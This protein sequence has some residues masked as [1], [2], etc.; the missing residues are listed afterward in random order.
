[1]HSPFLNNNEVI[2]I[3]KNLCNNYLYN[4]NYFSNFT[5]SKFIN[6]NNSSYNCTLY[7]SHYNCGFYFNDN[8]F[9]CYQFIKTNI[10][11]FFYFS[12]YNLFMQKEKQYISKFIRFYDVSSL[13]G[14]DLTD[15]V[16]NNFNRYLLKYKLDVQH[17]FLNSLGIKN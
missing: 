10:S 15:N 4:S 11:D 12:D 2:R 8:V 13:R 3:Y 14:V 9:V 7:F 6:K 5:I 16:K 1:M 17:H